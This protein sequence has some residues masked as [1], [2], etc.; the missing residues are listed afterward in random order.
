MTEKTTKADFLNCKIVMGSRCD[1]AG[2]LKR[3]VGGRDFLA[4]QMKDAGEGRT[5]CNQEAVS[6]GD[7]VSW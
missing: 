7:V 2:G 6:D 5:T 1:Y 4:D 3:D